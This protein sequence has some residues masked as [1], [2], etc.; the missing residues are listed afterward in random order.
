MKKHHCL[1]VLL[2]AL[3]TACGS[4][5]QPAAQTPAVLPPPDTEVG[6]P[7][8]DAANSPAP[9]GDPQDDAPSVDVPSEASKPVQSAGSTLSATANGKPWTVDE[10]EGL[11]G[12]N[13]L[14]EYEEVTL[15]FNVGQPGQVGSHLV[16][17][18]PFTPENVA[19]VPVKIPLTTILSAQLSGHVRGQGPDAQLWDSQN[20]KSGE[21]T[22][23]ELRSFG[24]PQGN[25]TITALDR[26][27]RTVS[28]KIDVTF[29]TDES[30]GTPTPVHLVGTF[31]GVQY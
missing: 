14:G 6:R 24:E 1:P 20:L 3:L 9:S 22:G 27:G 28:G 5:N 12:P 30:Q 7:V 26:A 21:S 11:S 13:L 2:L 17:R 19:N 29:T 18:L 15:R 4:N 25:V 31:D 10:I 23:F 16:L 8:T